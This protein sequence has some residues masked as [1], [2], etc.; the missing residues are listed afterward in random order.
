MITL[1][2]GCFM[3]YFICL[4]NHFK[5]RGG[6]LKSG[7]ER[8]ELVKSIKPDVEIRQGGLNV[9]TFIFNFSFIMLTVLISYGGQRDIYLKKTHKN[10]SLMT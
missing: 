2:A 6:M 8:N 9:F 5:N 1:P 4:L 3:V 10:I 7:W